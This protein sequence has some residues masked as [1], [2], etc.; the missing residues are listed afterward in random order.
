M[1]SH[2]KWEPLLHHASSS[3]AYLSRRL[4]SFSLLDLL[5][6]AIPLSLLDILLLPLLLLLFVSLPAALFSGLLHGL[7]L[8][9]H[10]AP[11]FVHLWHITPGHRPLESEQFLPQR[12]SYKL[13]NL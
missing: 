13:T 10:G 5:L 6:P 11:L 1:N 4:V 3:H 8:V 7:K 2:S 9:L 12:R